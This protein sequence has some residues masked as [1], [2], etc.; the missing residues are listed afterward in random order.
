MYFERTKAGYLYLKYVKLEYIFWRDQ[1][2]ALLGEKNG[3][4]IS[5]EWVNTG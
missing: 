4:S 1:T 3:F 5:I 2:E